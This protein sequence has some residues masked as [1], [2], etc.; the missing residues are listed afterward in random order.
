MFGLELKLLFELLGLTVAWGV[1]WFTTLKSLDTSLSTPRPWVALLTLLL[2]LAAAPLIIT[3]TG[4]FEDTLPEAIWVA[5][6]VALLTAGWHFRIRPD[7]RTIVSLCLGIVIVLLLTFVLWPR[8]WRSP[9][10]P[11]PE[12]L[13][14]LP[15][16]HQLLQPPP[17]S[18]GFLAETEKAKK[19]K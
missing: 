10:P 2:V 16:T 15:P 9:E 13:L 3:F 19:L 11:Q 17:I 7:A 4:R 1:F 6:T 5:P 14:S 8:P 18:P 12:T